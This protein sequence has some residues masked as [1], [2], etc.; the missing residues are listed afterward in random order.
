MLAKTV[1][2]SKTSQEIDLRTQEAAKIATMSANVSGK[3]EI[4]VEC[5]GKEGLSVSGSISGSVGDNKGNKAEV[6]VEVE[7]DGSLKATVSA[8]HEKKTGS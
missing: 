1:T 8:E 3:A 5:G 4:T 6:R 7:R 2:F